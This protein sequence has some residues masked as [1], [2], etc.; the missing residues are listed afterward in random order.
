MPNPYEQ[1][2]ARRPMLAQPNPLVTQGRPMLRPPMP[3]GP[4]LGQYG[5]MPQGMP[6]Q[7][8]SPYAA[9]M[10]QQQGGM[11]LPRPGGLPPG[12]PGVYGPQG[13]QLPP[14]VTPGMLAAMMQQQRG[15]AAT[16]PGQMTPQMGSQMSQARSNTGV[17]QNP[18]SA[19]NWA[20]LGNPRN[21]GGGY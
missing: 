13:G 1:F 7:A 9:F 16:A 11:G 15:A 21:R 18:A 2:Q 14:G 3:A 8:L 17:Q 4:P 5:Q 12:S 19:N 20:T 10:A 6:Q